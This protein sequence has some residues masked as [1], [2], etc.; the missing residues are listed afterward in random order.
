MDRQMSRKHL[1]TLLFKTGNTS[2][3]SQSKETAD[4]CHNLFVPKRLLKNYKDG[5]ENVTYF[6]KGC[7]KKIKDVEEC[8]VYNKC[9]FKGNLYHSI[10]YKR[11]T[12]TDDTVVQLKCGQFGRIIDIVNINDQCFLHLRLF[13]IC[14]NCPFK[15]VYHIQKVDCELVNNTFLT[16]VNNVKQK[17]IYI[18]VKNEQYLCTL[19]NTVEIQ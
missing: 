9:I 16:P 8:M 11:A 10:K 18:N 7:I 2:R 5:P 3:I 17:T 13:K 1:Q 14:S 6:G 4:Y 19:P 12:K 15:D